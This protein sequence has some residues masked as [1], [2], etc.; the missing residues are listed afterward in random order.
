MKVA[1]VFSFLL[2]VF[3]SIPR[4][5]AQECCDLADHPDVGVLICC[6]GGWVEAV[7][8]ACPNGQ[9]EEDICEPT[10][11]SCPCG[12]NDGCNS[13]FCNSDGS[14]GGCSENECNAQ[15]PPFCSVCPSDSVCCD[16]ADQPQGDD[17]PPLCCKDGTWVANFGDGTST[18]PDGTAV[19][20]GETDGDVCEPT[21]S[22]CPCGYNDGCNDCNCDALGSLTDCTE[23]ACLVQG[24][25]FCNDCRPPCCDL[26]DRPQGAI[27]PPLC[28]PDGTWA[29][30]IGDGTSVCPDGTTVS[31]GNE[32]DIGGTDGEVC[33]P[34]CSSCP[35]GYN[36][37]CN[38]CSCDALG[39]LTGCTEIACFVQGT[40]FCNDCRPP[41]CDLADRPQGAIESPLCCPDGTWAG[42]IG[43]GTS[44][45]PD[46][47]T[48]SFGN[49]GD[50]C[51][52]SCESCPCGYS[53]NCNDCSCD[54]DGNLIGC[55]DLAC[56]VQDPFFCKECDT[57]PR[58]CDLA[59]RPQDTTE[60]PLCCPDG[61]WIGDT[62]DG[63]GIC[64]DGTS[65]RGGVNDGDIC[66][67][68]CD[69]CPCGY[70]D[71]CNI[72]SCESDG[73]SICTLLFCFEFGT[74]SCGACGIESVPTC[75]DLLIGL[76]FFGTIRAILQNPRCL[77]HAMIPFLC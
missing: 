23:L 29:G 62:G 53:D 52:P 73:N 54:V 75:C 22:S 25:P 60:D 46:G 15:G 38:D 70:N 58:C 57:D 41:C 74:P 30:N 45:C 76:G 63:T 33:E 61:T 7:D 10:C 50:I 71:G 48:V 26:A 24:T 5:F 51:A 9:N 40:P 12:Y 55:T 27:E 35:C 44:I 37:G 17:E 11:S 6:Q 77:L 8:G 67:P 19:E 20:V 65:I 39:S 14:L 13:C 49:E 16:L 72:C 36:D 47:T 69:S 64:P 31:F 32:G 3:S 34:T 28:C 21:C 68:T 4:G 56:P 2:L 66:T 59:D 1:T 18:C 43:D 42:N